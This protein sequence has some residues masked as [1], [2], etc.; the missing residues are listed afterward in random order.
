[1]NGLSNQIYLLHKN[2][3]IQK[4]YILMLVIFRQNF[5][6]YI[7]L[8][9]GEKICTFRS[10]CK[11]SNFIRDTIVCQPCGW[12]FKVLSMRFHIHYEHKGPIFYLWKP[13]PSMKILFYLIKFNTCTLLFVWA[14]VLCYLKNTWV[15]TF[16]H[17]NETTHC[18]KF[19]TTWCKFQPLGRLIFFVI[20]WILVQPE[21]LLRKYG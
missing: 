15:F 7:I 20:T 21:R 18:V 17:L 6:V 4:L 14:T 13:L 3:E 10:H 2:E 9:C 16:D 5:F 11:I 12:N 8:K 1:M 19:K